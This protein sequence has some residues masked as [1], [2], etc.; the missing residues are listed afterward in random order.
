VSYDAAA[1]ARVAA[2]HAC[3]NPRPL[4][5]VRNVKNQPPQHTG[6][7]SAHARRARSQQPYALR[8]VHIQRLVQRVG[9]RLDVNIKTLLHLVEHR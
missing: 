1:G 7:P 4:T 8:G 6:A 2:Q 5:D 3:N 9:Q